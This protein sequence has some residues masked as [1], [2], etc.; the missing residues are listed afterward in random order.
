[1]ASRDVRVAIIGDPSSLQRALRSSEAA[2]A[3]FSQ[4]MQALGSRLQS[5]GSSLTRG[6]TLPLVGLGVV[7][8]RELSASQA[9]FAQTEAVIE[10][11]G[12]TARRSAED[13]EELVQ[14]LRDLSGVDDEG[15]QTMANTLLTFRGIVGETFDAAAEA[16]LDLSVAMSRDLQSSAVMVGRALNDPIRGMASLTRVG[17]QFTQQQRDAIAAMVYFGDTAGAQQI[18]LEELNAEFGGSAEALGGTIQGRLNRVRQRFEDMAASI[19]EDLLPVMEDLAGVVDDVSRAYG[20][21]DEDQQKWIA[22]FA[23]AALVIGPVT[24]ALGGLIG[25]V[26]GIAL[27]F[28]ALGGMMSMVILLAV[29]VAVGIAY[30]AMN[31]DGVKE[32]WRNYYENFVNNVP[33]ARAAANELGRAVEG[34][35]RAFN[36]AKAAAQALWN[37]GR[38]INGIVMGEVTNAVRGLETA[39]RSA[40][41]AAQSLLQTLID[42]AAQ[43][44]DKVS[45]PGVIPRSGGGSG[46][47]GAVGGRSRGPVRESSPMAEQIGRSVARE[48]SRTPLLVGGTF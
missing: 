30:I 45:G 47:G 21:M 39:L 44:L 12:G 34:I 32:A 13:I 1:M 48:L 27:G 41:S 5:V 19:L 36:A 17:V 2:T 23:L 8:Y 16:T 3:T 25:I 33:G 46:A 20:D 18:I 35:K 10:S 24:S 14:G 31:W 9:A 26:R 15:I 40:F 38:Q 22:G 4:R 37:V 42:I 43:N 11:T 7:A 29:A 28:A 6:L